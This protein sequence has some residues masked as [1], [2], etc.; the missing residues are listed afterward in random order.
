MTSGS[1]TPKLYLA[2][3]Y[4]HSFES[5]VLRCETL[6]DGRTVALLDSTYFYPESGGQV[7]DHGTIEDVRV[8]DVWEDG[9]GVVYHQ[10]ER[11]LDEGPVHCT[12][13]DARRF[14]HMQQHTGQ[15]ILSRALI[16]VA[17]LNT[18][19]FHMGEDACTIDLDGDAT[20]D[21]LRKGEALANRIVQEDREVA[22]RDVDAGSLD[23]EALRRKLPEGVTRARLVEVKG[24]DVIGC[25]GTHVRR[26][27][28][29]GVIKVLK[30]ERVKGSSRVTFKVGGRAY[31]DFTLKHDIVKA[32]TTRF[33]TSVEDVNE[34]IDKL[35]A[36]AQDARK[37]LQKALRHLA[38]LEAERLH[39]AA[40]LR[41]GTRIVAHLAEDGGDDYARLLSAELKNR[42]GTVNMI[43]TRGGTVVC[44]AAADVKIDFADT[45][46]AR[47]RE[48]G[49]SGGG[50]GSFANVRLPDGV[51]PQDFLNEMLEKIGTAL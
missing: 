27:G 32:L 7:A 1:G 14:D 50:K 23:N 24:F 44:N 33:T 5:R 35:A 29:L 4:T 48:L 6:G 18:I 26:S 15:H 30:Q 19:S 37:Q 22:V 46:I 42:P 34:K 17:A 38:G 20:D 43:A 10:L 40:V 31:R 28:E 25:C 21:D 16:E 11:A 3:P 41:G 45:V 51:A 2:D 9:D 12:V 13:D 47:V 39:E 36:E 8:L 49:G